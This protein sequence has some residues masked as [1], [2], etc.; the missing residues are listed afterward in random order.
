MTV[1]YKGN[2]FLRKNIVQQIRFSTGELDDNG[3][4]YRI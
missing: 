1:Y 2:L 3:N 4:F